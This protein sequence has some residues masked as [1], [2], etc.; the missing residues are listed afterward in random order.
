MRS[1]GLPEDKPIISRREMEK[2][3]PLFR[4]R[5][6]QS[7]G[8]STNLLLSD[9]L[10]PLMETR[11]LYPSFDLPIEYKYNG[12]FEAAIIKKID[13]G[14][15]S[16]NS[17]YGHDFLGNI[18]LQKRLK[19]IVHRNLPLIAKPFLRNLISTRSDISNS[20][21]L[22]DKEVSKVI[23]LDN[24]FISE[25]VDVKKINNPMSLSRAYTLEYFFNRIL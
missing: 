13:R 17:N 11:F 19:D 22:S 15:A 10:M 12:R 5:Y 18:P 6:F 14:L 21:L 7:M 2:S 20:D 25:Y 9:S 8:H 24:M 23:N 3:Y 1:I 4:Y 16:Y